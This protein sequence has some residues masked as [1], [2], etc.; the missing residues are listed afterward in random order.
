[1]SQAHDV[2]KLSYAELQ[3]LVAEVQERLAVKRAEEIKVLADAYAK[4]AQAAGF[5]VQEAMEALK[6]YLPAKGTRTGGDASMAKYVDPANPNNRWS[7]KGRAPRWLQTYVDT[8][9][10]KEDFRA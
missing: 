3:Q 6:P 5:S 9:K 8:G 10:S 1:M 4:K 2:S 7:G